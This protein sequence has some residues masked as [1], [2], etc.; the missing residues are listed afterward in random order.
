M[1]LL[2]LASSDEKM[3]SDFKNILEFRNYRINFVAKSVQFETIYDEKSLKHMF[4]KCIQCRKGK[5][6]DNDLASDRRRM[7]VNP[8]ARQY[9]N[10]IGDLGEEMN[11]S[12]A[13][14]VSI[15]PQ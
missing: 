3:T 14:R 11:R 15:K 12:S 8:D 9:E 5:V 13:F 4:F 10:V 1:D 7:S 6:D 2:T